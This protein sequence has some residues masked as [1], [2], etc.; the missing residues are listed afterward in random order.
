MLGEQEGYIAR[1]QNLPE[2]APTSQPVQSECVNK[3]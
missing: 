1:T 2:G 3:Y